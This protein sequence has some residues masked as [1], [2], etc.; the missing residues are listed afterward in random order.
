MRATLICITFIELFLAPTHCLWASS[1]DTK[2]GRYA[3][4]QPLRHVVSFVFSA[5]ESRMAVA[6]TSDSIR[7]GTS[8]LDVWNLDTDSVLRLGLSGS[9]SSV[10]FFPNE[11]RILVGFG[12]ST[13]A[14]PSIA[15][16]IECWDVN[17]K[18]RLWTW[19]TKPG[20]NRLSVSGDAKWIAF[21]A[22]Q[23]RTFLLDATS[24][25]TLLTFQHG[26]CPSGG[27]DPVTNVDFLGEDRGL[28]T[29]C[30]SLRLWTIEAPLNVK[31]AVGSEWGQDVNAVAFDEDTSLMAIAEFRSPNVTLIDR[32]ATPR[33]RH[34][35]SRRSAFLRE[36]VGLGFLDSGNMLAAAYRKK[37][38]T[39]A[40]S[41]WDVASGL[42]ATVF[43]GESWGPVRFSPSGRF[44]AARDTKGVFLVDLKQP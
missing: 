12:W 24:G 34:L 3:Q 41:K 23:Q 11:D 27:C 28:F 42:E 25:A 9:P 31:E 5:D 44:M 35:I 30:G 1:G 37:D 13:S 6:S 10:A 16:R 29:V 32:R 40:V 14:N 21:G 7:R 8:V 18:E 43:Q 39:L 22:S 19:T 26:P 2:P 4:V 15:G 36:A 20:V 38:G 17:R 33:F